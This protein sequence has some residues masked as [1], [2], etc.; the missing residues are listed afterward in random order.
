M[1][2]ET[3]GDRIRDLREERSGNKRFTQ[4]DLAE[5]MGVKSAK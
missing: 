3:I 1:Q 4:A 2:N 5:V